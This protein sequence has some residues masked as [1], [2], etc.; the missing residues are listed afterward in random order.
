MTI[1]AG[2]SA[3]LLALILFPN[4]LV[5]RGLSI[6]CARMAGHPIQIQG[7]HTKFFLF[8]AEFSIKKITLG[9]M[10]KTQLFSLNQ[11][12]KNFNGTERL[13]LQDSR[14]VWLPKRG[15]WSVRLL[16]GRIGEAALRAGFSLK[17]GKIQKIFLRLCVPENSL[18]PFSKLVDRRFPKFGDGTRVA[19]ISSSGGRWVLYG[20]SGRMLEAS[21]Q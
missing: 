15:G 20:A 16:D 17:N 2:A 1:L 18:E 4:P 8:G 6:Q 14:W 5:D 13:E 3:F 21:W 19:K 12:F 10:S 7:I 9:K 11:I